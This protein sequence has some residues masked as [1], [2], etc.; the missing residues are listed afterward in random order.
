MNQPEDVLDVLNEEVVMHF[1]RTPGGNVTALRARLEGKLDVETEAYPDGDKWMVR[2]LG[3]RTI[4]FTFLQP[5][6]LEPPR[7]P[8]S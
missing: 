4:D 3:P 5:D 8:P 7:R 2:F 6:V 1:I